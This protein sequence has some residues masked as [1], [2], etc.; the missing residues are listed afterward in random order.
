[1]SS[2]ES[3]LFG[4]F[5]A[6][7]PVVFFWIAWLFAS[8]LHISRKKSLVWLAG[9]LVVFRTAY[10]LFLTLG[11]RYIWSQ[12]EFSRIFLEFQSGQYFLEYVWLRFWFN[13][14]LSVGAAFLFWFFLKTLQKYK[15]RFFEEGETTLGLVFALSCGWPGVLLFVAAGLILVVIISLLRLVFLRESLTTLGPAMIAASALILYYGKA[16][17]DILNLGA[18]KI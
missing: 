13:V 2:L 12:N 4:S 3:F 7:L 6:N 11:Q 17:I 5:A 1:M 10:A 15:P 8:I 16:L 14:A 18:F 9:A